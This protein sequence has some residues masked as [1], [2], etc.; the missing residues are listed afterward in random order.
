MKPQGKTI[1]DHT[2]KLRIPKWL[3]PQGGRKHAELYL[4]MF[5]NFRAK[6]TLDVSSLYCIVLQDPLDSIILG[7][8][9]LLAYTASKDNHTVSRSQRT[10]RYFGLKSEG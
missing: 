1:D 5:Q 8:P 2:L 6:K 7:Y 3:G 4:P 10:R 9:V